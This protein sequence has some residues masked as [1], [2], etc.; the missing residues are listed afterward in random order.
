MYDNVLNLHM[1]IVPHTEYVTS[2][3][4][5]KRKLLRNLIVKKK[6]LTLSTQKYHQQKYLKYVTNYQ[7]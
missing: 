4:N 3:Y 6:L 7:T 5:S 2:K 1:Y